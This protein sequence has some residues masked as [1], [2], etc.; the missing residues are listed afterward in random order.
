M[1]N[2]RTETDQFNLSRQEYALRVMFNGWNVA[3]LMPAEQEWLATKLQ[4]ERTFTGQNCSGQILRPGRFAPSYCIDPSIR[5]RLVFVDSMI[6]QTSHNVIWS[7]ADVNDL[8]NWEQRK[9][10]CTRN[11]IGAEC[12]HYCTRL[13]ESNLWL[14]NLVGMLA[15]ME[16]VE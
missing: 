6:L 3:N 9:R 16:T 8:L 2:L 11:F 14:V 15:F 13:W 5:K 10:L 12:F 4:H 1:I 7:K